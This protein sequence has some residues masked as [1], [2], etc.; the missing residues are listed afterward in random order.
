[1][2]L[3]IAPARLDDRRRLLAELDTVRSFLDS[4][5]DVESMGRFRRQAFDTI[6]GGVATAF[7]LSKEDAKLVRRYDTSS[8]VRP[9]QISRKWNNYDNYVDNAKTLGKLLL[10]A[11]RLCEAGCGFVTVTTNFV[12]DM[13]AD[14]NNA[15][16]HEGMQY[17]G[18]PLDHA[19]SALIEDLEARGLRD[20][21]LLVVC[22]EMGRTPK[23]NNGGG[24]DHWGRIAP[25]LLYG[26]G[27]P[28]GQVIGQSARDGGEPASEPYVISNLI[29]TVMHTLVDV[30]KLRT[31]TGIPSDVARVITA[32]APIAG[33]IS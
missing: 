23:L 24:R 26:G 33:L 14:V 1:M 28:M 2:Q 17:M 6:L 13:H 5:S 12:W 11:R 18:R 7:D 21:I 25:L 27:L 19:V 8:L 22:G 15:G 3:N 31:L 30:G 9:D 32:S 20:K 16:M 29:A 10:L 4:R